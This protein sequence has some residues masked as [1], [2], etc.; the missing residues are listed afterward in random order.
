MQQRCGIISVKSVKTP[1]LA[2][3]MGSGLARAAKR[4]SNAAWQVGSFSS[5]VEC[6][7]SFL[8]RL[9]LQLEVKVNVML[10]YRPSS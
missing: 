4:S 5:T 6:S 3:T 7:V 8:R 1:R 9:F 10:I 2:F